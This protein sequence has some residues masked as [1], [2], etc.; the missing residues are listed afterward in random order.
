LDERDADWKKAMKEE[1]MTWTQLCDPHGFA[2]EIA[3]AYN[4]SGIPFSL[5]LDK[6]GRI[7]TVDVRGAQLD[8]ALEKL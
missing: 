4:I 2:G 6:E 7:I 3:K 1:A 8:L 5:L